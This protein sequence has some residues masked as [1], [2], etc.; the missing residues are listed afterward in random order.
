[1][2]GL[3]IRGSRN[4][5]TVKPLDSPPRDNENPDDKEESPSTPFLYECRIKGKVLKLDKDCYNPL[6]PGD[7][8]YVELEDDHCGK[9]M[10]VG[11]EPRRN[12][13]TRFNRKG[14]T[15]QIL[16]GNADQ[17][18]CITSFGSPPFRPRFI[19]RV[20]LQAEAS[21]IKALIVVNK[22]DLYGDREKQNND[23]FTE[24]E[25]R[26]AD[27]RRIGY[28][29]LYVSVKTGEGLD[30]LRLALSKR[31]SVFIGQSGVGKSSLINILL[32]EAQQKTGV[33]NEKYDRGNH[34]TVLS[35]LFEGDT[36]PSGDAG[37]DIKCPSSFRLTIVDTPGVR[38]LVP[39]GIAVGDIALY[40]K[41]FAP[42]AL[43][44]DFG[45][46]CS[47]T[48]E[49]GCKILE[50]LEEGNIHPDRYESFLRIKDE[51]LRDRGVK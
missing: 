17:I 3:V 45:S 2:K 6:A 31:L 24:I 49:A 26:L 23:E 33:L 7:I 42:L 44:C 22:A 10:I 41:E 50:A 20:L 38:Q 46:S 8:V 48:N 30:E 47:H 15:T 9:G 51:I 16:A 18:V 13:F 1:M 25:N 40:M 35:Q 34:T 21:G 27:Y 28:P 5:F 39:D 32:P 29:V 37:G 4:I 43:R 36:P 11:I 14:R 19:D 12:M